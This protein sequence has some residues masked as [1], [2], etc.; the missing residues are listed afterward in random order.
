MAVLPITTVGDPVLRQRAK[1]V[2]K[3]TKKTRRLIK[4]MADTLYATSNGIGLAAPQVGVSERIIVIDIGEGLIAMIN[5]R[6]VEASGS[7]VDIE[8]CLSIPGI[9]GYVERAARVVVEGLDE[10]GKPVRMEAESLLARVFQHEID[11]LDGILFTDKA[12]GL[13]RVEVPRE[14]EEPDAEGPGQGSAGGRLRRSQA[15][16]VHPDQD[17]SGPRQVAQGG[18]EPEAP[19]SAGGGSAR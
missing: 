7:E 9:S 4:D 16:P 14:E 1:P 11:H 17:E 5:P 10:R 15:E 19:G 18:G 13:H 8:G 6:I 2:E 12:T 3:I